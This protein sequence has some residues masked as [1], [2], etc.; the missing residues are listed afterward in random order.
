MLWASVF[1]VLRGSSH[2]SNLPW[3]LLDLP[4]QSAFVQSETVPIPDTCA[5]KVGGMVAPAAETVVRDYSSLVILSY[6]AAMS[7][8]ATWAWAWPFTHGAF[9]FSVEFTQGLRCE[10]LQ[11]GRSLETVRLSVLV[12]FSLCEL[13]AA[14]DSFTT[15]EIRWPWYTP[16]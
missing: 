6:L 3:T 8:G 13:F 5:K 14:D 7:L 1:R 15:E 2:Y 10:G 9:F 12:T 16:N 4:F 11:K